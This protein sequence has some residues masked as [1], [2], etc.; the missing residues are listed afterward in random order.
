STSL[1]YTLSL[2][3]ALP[4][5]LANRVV[6][7]SAVSYDRLRC[8][9]ERHC[10]RGRSVQAISRGWFRTKQLGKGVASP[11]ESA[12]VQYCAYFR[13]IERSEERRVGKECRWRLGA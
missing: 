9:Q 11:G 1:I 4:I 2:H 13:F 7:H 12:S 5:Y 3:D 10:E 6:R 8:D